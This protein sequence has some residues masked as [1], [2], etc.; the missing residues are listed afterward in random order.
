MNQDFIVMYSR[1]ECS[2][3]DQARALLKT[4]NAEFVEWKLDQH[5][6]RTALKSAFPTADT[7]PVIV[8]NG[9]FIGGYT[10]LHDMY[11]NRETNRKS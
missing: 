2:Y 3:C 6:S 8:V 11:K 10:Q 7:F 5:F 4:Q 1:N 9:K